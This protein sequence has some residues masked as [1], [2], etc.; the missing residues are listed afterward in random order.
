ME[1]MHRKVINFR[2]LYF[3]NKEFQSS[4]PNKISPPAPAFLKKDDEFLR[5][6]ADSEILTRGGESE[7]IE[8]GSETTEGKRL[9][10]GEESIKM[11]FLAHAAVIG[12][13]GDTK[14]PESKL[15]LNQDQH[16]PLL[17]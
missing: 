16:R 11:C 7:R 3:Q 9:Q 2:V 1:L 8:N 6:A 12:Q 17:R 10:R 13:R 4:N 5:W 14:A 15:A